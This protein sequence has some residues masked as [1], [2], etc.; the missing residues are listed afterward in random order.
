M[1]GSTETANVFGIRTKVVCIG[2]VGENKKRSIL[3]EVGSENAGEWWMHTLLRARS[4]GFGAADAP[5]P[6]DQRHS[7]H[8]VNRGN[9]WESS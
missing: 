5:G 3:L 9:F 4:D 2:P 1:K 8:S 7:Q 6:M